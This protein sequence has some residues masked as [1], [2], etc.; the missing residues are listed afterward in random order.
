MYAYKKEAELK[1]HKQLLLAK[2]VL[3]KMEDEMISYR[4]KIGNNDKINEVQDRLNILFEFIDSISSILSENTQ[5]RI[6]LRNSMEERSRLEDLLISKQKEIDFTIV[7]PKIKEDEEYQFWVINDNE[8]EQ[9]LFMHESKR[10]YDVEY[11]NVRIYPTHYQ[12]IEKPK[13]PIY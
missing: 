3:Y 9:S 1:P 10:W 13:P 12:P 2:G 6:L 5:I 4:L 7:E 8:L 11:L